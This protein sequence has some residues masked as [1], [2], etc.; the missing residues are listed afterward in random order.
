MKFAVAWFSLMNGELKLK[1]IEA[2]SELDAA[3]E[4]YGSPDVPRE[5]LKTLADFYEYMS[6]DDWVEVL[7]IE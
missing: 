1:V 3:F 5:E 4:V 6:D 7:P 2:D